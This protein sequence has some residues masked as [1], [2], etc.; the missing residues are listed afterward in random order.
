MTDSGEELRDLLEKVYHERGFDFREYRES[1]LTRR[2]G[3]RLRARG[4]ETYASY[5][6]LLDKDPSEYDRLFKDLTINVTSFFRDEVAFRALQ[7]IVLPTLINKDTGTPRNLRIWSAGCAT[8]EES[9]SIAM[10]LLEMLGPEISQRE[11][12]ILGTDVDTEALHRAREGWFTP[13][14]V[15]NIRPSLLDRYFVPEGDGFRVYSALKQLITFETHDLV[16]DSPYSALDLVVCRNVLIYFTPTLQTRVLKA[17]HDGLK[18]G[19]FLLLGKAEVLLGE[20]KTNFNCQDIKAKLFQKIRRKV[21]EAEQME[22]PAISRY[23]I[24]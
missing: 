16:T 6:H 17:F 11:V 20:A 5:A 3:R 9:Y 1:T 21:G 19:G 15:E 24:T 4:V 2:I 18:E 7:E 22:S 23:R 14:N 13:K 10:L 8:G 12:T